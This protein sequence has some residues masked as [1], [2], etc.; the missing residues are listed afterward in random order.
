MAKPSNLYEQATDEARRQLNVAFYSRL[1]L[2]DVP[3]A[4]FEAAFYAAQPA[5]PIGVG[6]Q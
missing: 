4:E 6:I 3:P 5:T 1:Y 2:D